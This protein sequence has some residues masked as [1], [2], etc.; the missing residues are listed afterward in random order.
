LPTNRPKRLPHR[1]AVFAANSS[2]DQAPIDAM[3]SKQRSI[4]SNGRSLFVEGDARS[5][6]ARRFRDLIALHSADLGGA[7]ALSEAQ[8]S[9]IRRVSTLEVELEAMESALSTGGE[10]NIGLYGTT[11]NT[12]RRLLETFG[13]GRVAIDKTPSL[14]DIIAQNRARNA[15]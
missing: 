6:W 8:K 9:L 14:D 3:P 10:A 4:V 11:A 13:I 15:T 1:V 12:I 2:A 7:S 5:A